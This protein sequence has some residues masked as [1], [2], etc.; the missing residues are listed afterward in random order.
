MHGNITFNPSFIVYDA[1]WSWVPFP[2]GP[3]LA[4]IKI[5]LWGVIWQQRKAICGDLQQNLITVITNVPCTIAF[6]CR[7]VFSITSG[8]KL[9]H[10]AS[11]AV[12]LFVSQHDYYPYRAYLRYP[13]LQVI[14]TIITIKIELTEGNLEEILLLLRV[15]ACSH[16]LFKISSVPN[17]N[18]KTC[19]SAVFRLR[20]SWH[21]YSDGLSCAI[22]DLIKSIK[23][24]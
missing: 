4:F 5:L 21:V 23:N 20:Q 3:F 11:I 13:E 1:I 9:T 19:R 12:F 7:Y 15:P 24:L 14:H 22:P 17:A 10:N 6:Y 18:L 2:D 16:N 8:W